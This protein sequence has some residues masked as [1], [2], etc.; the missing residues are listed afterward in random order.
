MGV[1]IGNVLISYDVNK[2][3]VEVK[4]ALKEK[5]YMETWKET[6]ASTVYVLPNTTLWHNKKSTDEAIE[7]LKAVCVSLLVKLEK[8]VAIRASEF[9]G[10]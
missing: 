7:D 5:G 1:S 2:S 4:N 8:A 10:I 6:N 9:V 3:H